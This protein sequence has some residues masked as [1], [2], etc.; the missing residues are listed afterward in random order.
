MKLTI[1]YFQIAIGA[2][3]IKVETVPVPGFWVKIN[4]QGMTSLTFLILSVEITPM[5]YYLF[6]FC[7]FVFFTRGP[8]HDQGGPARGEGM[9]EVG[10]QP[11]S[12]MEL[13]VG[14]TPA[15]GDNLHIALLLYRIGYHLFEAFA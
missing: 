5:F 9:W 3:K 11:R 7:F 14:R 13:A 4:Y 1:T 8:V 6:K 2:L 15:P 10:W 12:L